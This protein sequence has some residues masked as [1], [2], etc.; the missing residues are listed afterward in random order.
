MGNFGRK[1][2]NIEETHEKSRT[3]NAITKIKNSLEGF[4]SIVDA[5]E[6]RISDWKI[7]QK[8]IQTEVK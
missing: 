6:E 5:V 4:N 7:G 2:E 8:K 1:L 3:E